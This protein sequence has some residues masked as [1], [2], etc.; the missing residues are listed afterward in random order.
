MEQCSHLAQGLLP[1]IRE[2]LGIHKN[3]WPVL[4]FSWVVHPE[5]AWCSRLTLIITVLAKS[6]VVIVMVSLTSHPLICLV[7]P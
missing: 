1:A 4:R 7:I 3:N 5:D 6:N 2:T